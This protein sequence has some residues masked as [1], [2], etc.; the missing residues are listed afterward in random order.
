MK[1]LAVSDNRLPQFLNAQFLNQ[2]FADVEVLISCGDMDPDYLDFI[3][4]VLKIPLYYVRGNHDQ[5]Y[6]PDDPGGTDL[7][8]RIAQYKG[9]LMAGL[10]GS[11]RYNVGSL[12]Y[13]EAEMTARILRILPR[14][15][16]RRWRYGVGVDLLATHSPPRNI[17]DAEDRAHRGFRSFRWLMR[18]ARPRYLIHGHVDIYDQRTPREMQYLRTSVININPSRVITIEKRR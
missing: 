2:H 15:L 6:T 3:S 13:S 16:V 8:C 17:N 9:I 11:L 10:E 14:L 18:W 4:T 7:H 1:I 12:Q 5:N